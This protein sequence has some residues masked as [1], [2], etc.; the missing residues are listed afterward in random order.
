MMDQVQLVITS[1][2]HKGLDYFKKGYNSTVLPILI[3]Q[4]INKVLWAYS[5]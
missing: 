2:I 1:Y 4:R 5:W 3:S